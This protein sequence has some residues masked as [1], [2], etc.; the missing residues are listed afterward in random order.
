MLRGRSSIT[1][2][3]VAPV[4]VKPE[5]DSNTAPAIVGATPVTTNGT[6]PASTT[7]V[8]PNPTMATPSR[9]LISISRGVRRHMPSPTTAVP[10]TAAI[11]GTNSPSLAAYTVGSSMA[12]AVHMRRAPITCRTSR[13]FTPG[14]TRSRLGQRRGA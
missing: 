8:H 13:M 9:G 7:A 5:T 11:H 4:V 2:K 6:A 14:S 10:S 1:G 3:I 12:A